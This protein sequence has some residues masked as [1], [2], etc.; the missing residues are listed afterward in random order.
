MTLVAISFLSKIK[1]QDSF[2][3]TVLLTFE[4]ELEV[5]VILPWIH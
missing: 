1:Q 5:Y 4:G 2:F 3:S